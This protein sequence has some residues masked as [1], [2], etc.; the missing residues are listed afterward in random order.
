MTLEEMKQHEWSVSWSGGKDST[1]T[2]ILMHEHQVPIKEII[3]VRMMWD[4]TTPATLPDMTEFVDHAAEV[5][6]SWGYKVRIIPSLKTAKSLAEQVYFKSVHTS[7]N[8]KQYGI[9]AFVR[10]C[11]RFN[12]TKV[13]T[14]KSTAISGFEMIGYAA[15]ETSRIHRLT[16]QKCSIMVEMGITESQAVEICKNYNL[17]APLYFEGSTMRDGCWFCPNCAKR[18]RERIRKEYPS[19]YQNIVGMIQAV[20]SW[21]DPNLVDQIASRN[22]WLADYE[23]ERK[24]KLQCSFFDGNYEFKKVN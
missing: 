10:G 18:E 3:Y 8:G 12:G 17:L 1:A 16:D 13:Q 9:S 21:Q 4:E 23:T 7:K 11:C 15:D 5:F 20:Y 2:I 14:I 6:R 19:L 24:Q 22:H